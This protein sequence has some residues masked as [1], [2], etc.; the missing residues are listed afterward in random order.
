[1]L[2]GF[3]LARQPDAAPNF[4]SSLIAIWLEQPGVDPRYGFHGACDKTTPRAVGPAK[5]AATLSI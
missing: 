5:V 3:G 2:A 1:L 4:P